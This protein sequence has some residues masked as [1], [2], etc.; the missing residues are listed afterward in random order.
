MAKSK[1]TFSHFTELKNERNDS[2][3]KLGDDPPLIAIDSIPSFLGPLCI[4]N[5]P[6]KS[7]PKSENGNWSI[8][9]IFKNGRR[10]I[11]FGLYLSQ[12]IDRDLILVAIPMFSGSKNQMK[13]I[14]FM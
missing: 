1:W 11:Y 2:A 6:K 4:R 3:V 7:L 5:Q 10:Q 8:A 9:A 12:R 13:P 14:L